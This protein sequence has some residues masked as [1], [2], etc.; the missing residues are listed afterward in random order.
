M[1]PQAA[2]DMLDRLLAARGQDVVLRKLPST[3]ITV[4]ALVRTQGAS[5]LV[6]G[7]AQS[8]S[9]VIISPTQINAAQWPAAQV[10]G[11]PDV[12]IPTKSN[13]LVVIENSQR[14]VQNAQPVYLD[15]VL[16]RIDISVR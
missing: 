10:A 14:F 2:I 11:K 1:T 8:D 3:D 5:D 13:F 16:V 15:D 12:R 6:T 7:I 9:T 4:R